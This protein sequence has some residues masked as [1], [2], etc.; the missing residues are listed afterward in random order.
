MDIY[1]IIYD[2]I[3]G[4]IPGIEIINSNSN[5][6]QPEQSY[7]SVELL[8]IDDND[9]G[10]YIYSSTNDKTESLNISSIK[11]SAFKSNAITNIKKIK[12]SLHDPNTNIF[13]QENKL[14]VM[15]TG[16]IRNVP[17]IRRIL[18]EESAY[19]E[20]SFSSIETTSFQIE[21]IEK[22]KIFDKTIEK[23]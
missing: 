3:I 17:K 20:V 10:N 12:K 16:A 2:W 13:F 5:V 1:D 4:I 8:D 15:N 6:E 18:W 9:T 23:P 14:G 19:F 22:I 11:I 21:K 7:I